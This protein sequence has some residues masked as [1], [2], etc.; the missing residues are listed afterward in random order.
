MFFVS[1]LTSAGAPAAE[2]TVTWTG[3]FSDLQCASARAAGGV[4]SSTNPD[5]ARTCI[6]KGAPPVF[7]SED[8]KAVFR[9]T[10]YDSAVSDLGYHVSVKANVESENTIRILSVTRLEYQGAACGRPKKTVA[11]DPR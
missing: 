10:G 8:A 2:K 1:L 3:W 5:C 11:K 7:I 9:V 4:F 6:E